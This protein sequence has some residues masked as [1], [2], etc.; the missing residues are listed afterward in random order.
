MLPIVSVP[1]EAPGCHVARLTAVPLVNVTV[2]VPA[3]T[4]F[5]VNVRD[6]AAMSSRP[7]SPIS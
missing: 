7:V 1:G 6:R 3:T 5:W 4:A 2:P